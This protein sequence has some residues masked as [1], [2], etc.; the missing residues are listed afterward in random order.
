[1]ILLLLLEV[2]DLNTSSNAEWS[3]C[4][5]H[6]LCAETTD[7]VCVCVEAGLEINNR[8]ISVTD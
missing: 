7:W 2:K 1:M 3:Q 6:L 8:E 5:V 4:M